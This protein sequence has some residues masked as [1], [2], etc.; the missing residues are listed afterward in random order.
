MAEVPVITLSIIVVGIACRGRPHVDAMPVSLNFFNRYYRQRARTSR[1]VTVRAQ[2]GIESMA[3]VNRRRIRP[4]RR[5]PVVD[6]ALQGS[7]TGRP[8]LRLLTMI[9]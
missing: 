3:S 1:R 8:R 5:G 9:D 7:G 4:V 6:T 2:V